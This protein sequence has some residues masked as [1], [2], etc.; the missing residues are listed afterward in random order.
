MEDNEIIDKCERCGKTIHQGSAYVCLTR[1]IEQIE[2]SIAN[3][4]DEIQ[5]IQSDPLI[6][7]CGSCGNMF[8]TE[9]LVK[10]IRLTPGGK[11]QN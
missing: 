11:S 6:T 7:L 1:N 4:E 10:L 9:T 3:N 2:H 8:D 5:I